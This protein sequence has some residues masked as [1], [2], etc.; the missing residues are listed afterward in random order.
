MSINVYPAPPVEVFYDKDGDI[1]DAFG[2]VRVSN[3]ITV[4]DSKQLHDAAPLFWDDEQVSGTANTSHSTN[5]A[6]TTISVNLNTDGK[7]VRQTFQRFNYQ[8]GKSQ[9]VMMTGVLNKSGGGTGITRYIGAFD[10]NNGMFIKDEAGT[11]RFGIRSSVTGSP[12]NTEIAQTAWNLDPMDGTGSSG[13]TIDF[14]KAQIFVFCYEWLSVG[15]VW[16]GF[17]IDGKTYYAHRFDHANSVT[18]AYMSTPNL[19]LRYEIELSG[20]TGAASSLEHICTT[21]I[22]EGG[23]QDNGIIRSVSTAGTPVDMD[24]EDTWYSVVG[25]RLR[26][27]HLDT[28]I[29]LTSAH[30]QLQSASDDAEWCIIFNPTEGSSP[31]WQTNLTNSACEYYLGGAAQITLTGGT[32]LQRGYLST[33]TG[34][35][36]SGD[37]S[38]GL[39]NALVLGATRSGTADRVVLA[40]RPINGSSTDVYVEGALEWREL[41]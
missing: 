17:H 36:G 37:L 31:T 5:T 14:S 12:V 21:V 33:G 35:A 30:L 38:S 4:F 16:C 28:T 19:P 3:P 13:I 10:E 41:A 27:T 34:P 22:S 9:L 26:S 25:L 15:S 24:T 11:Y 18:G 40:C 32:E 6:S 20:G 23:R 7:R 29:K 2:R 39:E 8:P 1:T